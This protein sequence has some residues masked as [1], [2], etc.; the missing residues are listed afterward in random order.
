MEPTQPSTMNTY[1]YIHTHYTHT[2]YVCIYIYTLYYTHRVYVYIYTYTYTHHVMS[3]H[4][5]SCHIC[6][7]IPYGRGIILQSSPPITSLSFGDFARPARRAR[8]P[9]LLKRTRTRKILGRLWGGRLVN[10]G[11]VRK[12]LVFPVVLWEINHEVQSFN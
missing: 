3:C 12:T 4:D 1:I 9:R 2:V 8:V 10:S 6:L 11:K 5:M 7:C